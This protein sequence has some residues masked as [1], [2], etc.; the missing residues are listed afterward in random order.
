[1]Y[2]YFFKYYVSSTECPHGFQEIDGFCL[3]KGTGEKTF[4]EATRSCQQLGGFLAEPRTQEINTAVQTFNFQSRFL[5][6]GLTDL[7]ED[8]TFLWQSN[9]AGLS[10]T[11][12]A[13][14]QPN[15]HQ[16]K[17][18]CVGVRKKNNNNNKQW[19]DRKCAEKNEY[20]CQSC[21][22]SFNTYF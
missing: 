4:E 5:W 3:V 2:L 9:N 12:W 6:I 20:L 17:Q 10:Y 21:K 8:E 22:F 19:N 18:H 7:A 16:Y 11:D 14:N 1:M 13:P 15:N